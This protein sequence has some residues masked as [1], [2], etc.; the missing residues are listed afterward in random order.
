M[1]PLLEHVYNFLHLQFYFL[2]F[3]FYNHMQ[4]YVITILIAPFAAP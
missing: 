1:I 2:N 4:F 3:V